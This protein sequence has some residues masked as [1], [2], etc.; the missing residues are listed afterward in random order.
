MTPCPRPKG[1][2]GD[3][4]LAENR[5]HGFLVECCIHEA[6]FVAGFFR[7]GTRV[8]VAAVRLSIFA[9]GGE[10]KRLF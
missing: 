3:H 10:V 1:T 5:L 4:P 2:A 6:V 9:G 8:N 7:T